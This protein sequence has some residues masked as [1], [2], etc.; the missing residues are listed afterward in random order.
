MQDKALLE[1]A[2][3]AV[4][5][6]L[7]ACNGTSSGSSSSAAASSADSS[8]GNTPSSTPTSTTESTTVALSAASYTVP[9]QSGTVVLTVDR[10]GTASGP[11]SVSYT[12][13]NG[14]ARAGFDYS[15]TSGSL[16]WSDGDMSPK[17]I[18]VPVASS[19][20]G[21]SFTVSLIAA[22]GAASFGSP[23]TATVEIPASAASSPPSSSSSSSGGG[24][25]TP[26]VVPAYYVS[27]DG[28]DSNSGSLAAP[29]ATL[30]KAQEVMES[31]TIKTTYI[32]AGQYPTTS[33][34]T[35]T[36]ADSGTTWQY[37]PSDGP[38]TAVFD[39]GAHGT[40]VG[41]MIDGGSN[42]TINGLKMTNF[43]WSGI[44]VHGGGRDTR[45]SCT[46]H[47]VGAA[48]ENQIINN[49]ISGTS[50]IGDVTVGQTCNGVA[51]DVEGLVNDTVVANNYVHDNNCRGI[52]LRNT[53]LI[54]GAV[55]DFSGSVVK[56]N[57][58]L[59]N[60]LTASDGAAIYVWNPNSFKSSQ[61]T[62]TN[63]FIR[64]YSSTSNSGHAGHALYCDYEC[65][66]GT[67]TFN[68][69]TGSS[70]AV[71]FI[72]NDGKNNAFQYNV[73][74]LNS[75]NLTAVWM[76]ESFDIHHQGTPGNVWKNNIIIAKS[77]ALPEVTG[78]G[79]SLGTNYSAQNNG[80]PAPNPV[81]PAYGSNYYV[82]LDTNGPEYNAGTSAFGFS[83]N[84]NP[85]FTTS[86]A[87][88]LQCWDYELVA[89]S[90]VTQAPVS[91]PGLP[92]GWGPPGFTI[93]HTGTAPSIPLPSSCAN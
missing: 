3:C 11:A 30:A 81:A 65:S 54:S 4:L 17:T 24:G 27:A 34:F 51:I 28:N 16:S 84:S 92:G 64:D 39:G 12:T 87:F 89:G 91:F 56:N 45:N 90:P 88:G 33:T 9:A 22:T 21:K 83:D 36:A 63:N 86:S 62:V 55:G 73:F 47:I 82:Q 79:L 53:D 60:M 70:N 74:D 32:R 26:S 67:W 68:V 59:N 52:D 31:S 14:T 57:A 25:T 58:L 29:F 44:I 69:I 40:L 43:I 78:T 18:H 2:L 46:P 76:T 5:I 23:T 19:A 37:Y 1:G 8:S 80:S 20:N 15:A 6:M 75:Q 10:V 77:P 49:E 71:A 35:L 7:A 42:I 38:G 41:W 61:W 48:T 93:P 72:T 13:V 66:N 85:T 50:G